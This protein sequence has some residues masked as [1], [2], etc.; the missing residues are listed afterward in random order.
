MNHSEYQLEMAG[1]T[2]TTYVFDDMPTLT[3]VRECH[4]K[5]NLRYN[6]ITFFRMQDGKWQG[7]ISPNKVEGFI[8]EA[9]L[10]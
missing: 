10:P 5:E 8:E 4:I 6:S 3:R 1:Y 7:W 2:E 9:M